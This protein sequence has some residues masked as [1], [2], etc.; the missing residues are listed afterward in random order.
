MYENVTAFATVNIQE[1]VR[2][3]CLKKKILILLTVATEKVSARTMSC[4]SPASFTERCSCAQV[5]TLPSLLSRSTTGQAWYLTGVN[6]AHSTTPR[7][8]SKL[9]SAEHTFDCPR[10]QLQV[11]PL[12][13][14]SSFH[15]RPLPLALHSGVEAQSGTYSW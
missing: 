5:E 10:G 2:G 1:N 7:R 4:P 15:L 11:P 6:P 9:Q 8:M 12:H 3:F 14:A 13:T